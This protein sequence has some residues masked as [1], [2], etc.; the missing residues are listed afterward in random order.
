MKKKR[1][2][3]TKKENGEGRHKNCPR[4]LINSR[5][6][7]VR[8]TDQSSLGSRCWRT[9]RRLDL[10]SVPEQ[11]E[12]GALS[13]SSVLSLL[14]WFLLLSL[15]TSNGPSLSVFLP[16]SIIHNLSPC[17]T[18]GLPGKITAGGGQRL[19]GQGSLK[20]LLLLHVNNIYFLVYFNVLE[21]VN[22][23]YPQKMISKLYISV[24][25]TSLALCLQTD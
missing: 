6:E 25:A 7:R 18:H 12:G 10:A 2:G 11:Q 23:N 15:F 8:L 16:T 13:T 3:T 9:S 17:L 1:G 21:T 19:G 24:R 22:V 20:S 5:L 4:C 14:L